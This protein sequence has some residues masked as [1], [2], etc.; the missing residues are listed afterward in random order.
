MSDMAVALGKLAG[1]GKAASAAMQEN[2]SRS[3]KDVQH[4]RQFD[5]LKHGYLFTT[6]IGQ[7][8]LLRKA[9]PDLYGDFHNINAT[10]SIELGG[11]A[12]GTPSQ[13]VY[14]RA[15]MEALLRDI[16]HL[17]EIRAA[18]QHSTPQA[19]ELPRRVFISHGRS[20]DWYEVQQYVERDLALRTMEL[21]QEPS[22]GKTIIEKLE[23]GASQCDSAVIV[24]SGDDSDADG[25][26][27]VRENVMHEIGYFH[28]AYGRSR[29]VLLHEDGVSVPT[30]LAGIVYSA[31]PKG[32]VKATFGE[33][34]RE[35]HAIYG[36]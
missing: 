3:D 10:P 23:S 4:P 17:I 11:P 9:A 20:K 34:G 28:A 35:L 12:M 16:D 27:R 13:K 26:A 15:D 29:V 33:L 5:P 7:L 21:S 32:L 25:A 8:D 14:G 19:R 30:N 31:Y 1:I 18:V 24:M 6:A 2:V 36:S 22:Q